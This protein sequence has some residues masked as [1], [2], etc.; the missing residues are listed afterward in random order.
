MLKVFWVELKIFPWHLPNSRMPQLQGIAI[1]LAPKR[2]AKKTI[3]AYNF[4]MG[5]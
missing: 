3:V 4:L 1:S 2:T 5:S